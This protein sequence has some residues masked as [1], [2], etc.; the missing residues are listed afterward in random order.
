MLVK[1]ATPPIRPGKWL[2]DALRAERAKH[3]RAA[4]D[5]GEARLAA[6]Q[7][8]QSKFIVRPR[9]C[10]RRNWCARATQWVRWGDTYLGC[11]PSRCVAVDIP[12]P[13]VPKPHPITI[14]AASAA[15]VSGFLQTT[16]PRLPRRQAW[17]AESATRPAGA[18]PIR[19]NRFWEVTLRSE[20]TP[21]SGP[22]PLKRDQ[23]FLLPTRPQE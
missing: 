10:R 7:A 4:A 21:S 16:Q 19:Y 11:Q 20:S 1:P 6:D 23:H 13:E 18:G 2:S 5:A 3:T 8:A 14:G 17:S 15:S 12:R 22:I 9:T